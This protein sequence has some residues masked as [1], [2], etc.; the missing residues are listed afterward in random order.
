[1]KF[2]SILLSKLILSKDIGS[3]NCALCDKRFASINAFEE[4]ID[5]ETYIFDASDCV[6]I[7]K[8]YRSVYGNSFED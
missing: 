8:K 3:V 1:M 6:S 5:S 7:F 4:I 2:I